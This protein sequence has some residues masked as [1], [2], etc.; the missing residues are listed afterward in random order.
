[1]QLR[2]FELMAKCKITQQQLSQA[3][4]I[5]QGN[6]S[7]WKNNRSAPKA[8]ALVKIADYFNV[9]TDYLL[10]LTDDPGQKEK[11]LTVSDEGLLDEELIGRLC[12]LTP[13][14]LEKVDAFVQGILA[15]H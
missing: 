8:E 15:S 9:T 6:I 4:G 5:S 14:E 10:G 2:L 3:T 13:E 1:M 12:R 7:D 11:P